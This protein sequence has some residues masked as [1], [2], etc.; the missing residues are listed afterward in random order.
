MT[1]PRLVVRPFVDLIET[2]V[3]AEQRRLD[4]TP[5]RAQAVRA[6]RSS[7]QTLRLCALRVRKCWL[8][9]SLFSSLLCTI[10]RT[11]THTRTNTHN[12]AGGGGGVHWANDV[13][14]ASITAPR[15]YS[16]S[17]TAETWI[18][19][20]WCPDWVKGSVGDGFRPACVWAALS[21]AEEMLFRLAESCLRSPT[22][23]EC[24]W[25]GASVTGHQKQWD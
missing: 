20:L 11:G 9:L 5:L 24:C 3:R 14:S 8:E 22:L 7:A 23:H 6:A 2:F 25:A 4:N 17:H 15:L 16:A 19:N 21:L 1:P 13:H 10:R 18:R 12:G